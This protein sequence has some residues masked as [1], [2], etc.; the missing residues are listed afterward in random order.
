[1][2][3]CHTDYSLLDSC[4]KFKDY[5]DLA[6]QN[7][8]RAISFSEHGKPLGW[9]YKKLACDMEKIKFIHSVEIYL[10][11]SLDEKVR[12][13]YHTVLLAKNY[14]GVLELN[15]LVSLSCRPDHFYYNNR[16]TFDEFL[17]ISPNII[18]TSACLASPLRRLKEDNPYYEKMV[19]KY[20]FLEIQPH[21]QKDQIEFNRKLL[22]LSQ[23]YNKPLIA[24]TDTHSSSKYKAECR[25]VLLSSKHK[26]YGDED[27]FDLSYKT[28]DELVDMFR[29]QDAIPEE[30]YMEAIQ[31][32][33]VLADMVDEFELDRS[34][35]YPILYGSREEDEQKYKEVVD[36]KFKEKLDS[37]V[38]PHEQEDAFRKAIDEELETLSNMG[39]NGFMLSMSELVSW[40]KENGMA[41]GTARGSVGGSRVAYVSDIIDMNPETWGTLFSRFANPSRIEVGDIDTD[42]IDTDR[43][44][45]FKHIVEKFGE[46]KTARVASFGTIQ[47]KGVIDEVGRHLAH[48]WETQ[49]P[50]VKKDI[51]GIDPNP[52]NLTIMSRI[53]REFDADEN[54]TKQKYPELFY[55][56]DGLLNVKVSQS[57]H[58]AGMVISPVT[59]ADHYGTFD[60][61]GDNCLL[62]DMDEAHD[63]GLV[64]YDFLILKSV[65][66]IRDCCNYIGMPYP[67]SHEIDFDDQS[68][69]ESIGKNQDMIFQFESSFGADCLKRFK[70]KSIF[71]MSLVT[72]CMRPSGQ[73][74][75]DQLLKRI[76]HGNPSKIIDNLLEK[77]YGYLVYQED[78]IKFMTDICG[79]DGSTADSVRRGIAKK[80]M[81][82]LEKYLPQIVEG[83]CSKSDKPREEAEEEVKEYLKVIED[84]SAYMFN[85]SH[86]V[87][88]C[89]LGYYYGYFRHYYPLE[90]VTSYLNNAANDGDIKTGTDYASKV[91]IHVTMPKWG[92]SKSEYFYDKEKNIIAKGISSIKYM[93]ED[94]ANQLYDLSHQKTYTHFVDLLY[95]IK[96]ETGLDSRQLDILIKIDFFGDFGNQRELL[97]ITDLFS[98][99]F[100]SGDAKQI[101]RE[102]VENSQIGEIVKKYAVGT[103][104]SGGIAKSYTLLDIRSI[105]QESED[106]IKS[107]GLKDLS[108][109]MKV[110]NFCDTLGYAGYVSGK[111]EDRRKLYVTEI[112][113]VKRKKDN[114]QFGYSIL[115]KSIGSGKDGR[116]TVFNK[117][118][119]AD[120]IHKGDIILCKSFERDGIYFQLTSYE[121]VV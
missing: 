14:D 84:A 54:K 77:N 83:Y 7:N 86:S 29:I 43:P 46:D 91:G 23:K 27:A 56:F 4:T 90:F 115:T 36:R 74:Y 39:M 92:I 42:V 37:G 71:D 81:E 121:K 16:L 89:L 41:I 2:Y 5:I 25:D 57:V 22:E 75:R 45:I 53:K 101:K 55:Y 6:V 68:V 79:L 104:K 11:E 112:Y 12:D 10:T 26:S 78:I 88:Y 111:E 40:C 80:K 96:N 120:P 69:W 119:D 106:A 113:P 100:K 67:K 95:D 30:K 61:E 99:K 65:K 8:Q 109:V 48:V 13:N 107:A 87:A 38:I 60:K 3:H 32:T 116:F 35:K 118:Y 59:L 105:L 52:W 47:E 1:M 58:P 98:N 64:K 50:G 102:L 15:S 18:T 63:A 72:A 114:K 44:A 28:Y 110:R 94:I 62:L 51:D 66:V 33:N 76:V 70:C 97:Y 103:T 17:N 108:D 9:L 93:S 31:N 24:G 49:H 19:M 73:S 20:D 21:N 117:L 34:I 85:Y 82:I